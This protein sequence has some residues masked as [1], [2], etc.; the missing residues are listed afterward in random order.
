MKL[1]YMIKHMKKQVQVSVMVQ[2]AASS[3]KCKAASQLKH[4]K[5]PF[6]ALNSLFKFIVENQTFVHC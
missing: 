2:T 5:G 6:F 1:I 3:V 4:L